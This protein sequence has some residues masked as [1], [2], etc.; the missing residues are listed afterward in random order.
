MLIRGPSKASSGHSHPLV[1]LSQ[2]SHLQNG[3][4][5]IQASHAAL[6]MKG[7]NR[8]EHALEDG[9]TVLSP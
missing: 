6:R 9:V 1:W 5:S 2:L 3:D 7:D 4:L 8:W